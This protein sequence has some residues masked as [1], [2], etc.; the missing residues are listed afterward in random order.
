MVWDAEG[1]PMIQGLP[2]ARI[3]ADPHEPRLEGLRQEARRTRQAAWTPDLYNDCRLA[4]PVIPEAGD[5]DTARAVLV[6]PVRIQETL[7]AWVAVT[8]DTG[9]TFTPAELEL[10]QALADQAA[11]GIANARACDELER[12]RAAQIK[13]E[14]LVAMGRLAA[15]VAH[16]LRNPLQNLVALIAELRDRPPEG[17]GTARTLRTTSRSSGGPEPRPGAPP[18]S[19]IG[20]SARCVSRPWSWRR[21]TSDSWSRRPSRSS[22]SGPPRRG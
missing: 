4:D 14:R 11:L 8:G 6:A 15:W 7:L 5:G 18:A 20:C 3:L 2:V 16:E 13:Q 1:R 21:P 10:V 17:G 22:P 19:S 9:S 12:S